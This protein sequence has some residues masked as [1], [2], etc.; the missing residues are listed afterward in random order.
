[1]RRE[2]ENRVTDALEN[3]FGELD[4]RLSIAP[5]LL[6][7]AKN[8]VED[9]MADYLQELFR[10]KDGS[11]LE[12]LDDQ[13]LEVRYRTL[14]TNSVGYMLLT[15][16]GV[17]PTIYFSDEDF[18]GIVDFNTRDTLNTLGVATGD[19]GQMCL[20]EIARTVRAMERQ[21]Q[22][23]KSHICRDPEDEYPVIEEI[24]K[25]ERSKDHDRTELQNGER[26]PSAQST[27]S[28]RA[29]GDPWE[30][31]IDETPVSAT[32][33]QSDL[34]EP[35]DQREADGAS[36]GDREGSAEPAGSDHSADGESRRRDGGAESEGSDD[37]GAADE[38]HPAESRGDDPGGVDL[39]LSGHDFD[40]R[41]DIPFYHHHEEKQEIIRSGKAL[42]DH[43]VT[44][45][46][47]LADHEDRKERGIFVKS[48]FDPDPVEMT[49]ANGQAAGYQAFDDLLHVWRGN[50]EKP[51]A[52]EFLRWSYVADTIEGMI[53]MEQWFAPE[54]QPLP[55]EGEQITLLAES[56]A[57]KANTFVFPQAAIDYIL[58]SGSGI[59]R[60]KFRI[61]E[62]FQLGETSEE[63]VRFLK[64]EYGTGGRTSA[65]PG[66]GLW[67]DHDSKGITIKNGP[68]GAS[69]TLRWP[70]VEKRIREL[71]AAN[72]YLSESEKAA[73]PS[74][75][76]ARGDRAERSRMASEFKEIVAE[77]ENDLYELGEKSQLPSRFYLISS[78]DALTDGRKKVYARTSEGDFVLP[79][80][81]SPLETIIANS[82][83][84]AGRCNTLLADLNGELTKPLEPT[85][86]E[87]NPP[88][89][90][91]REYLIEAGAIVHVGAQE[92]EVVFA[93]ADSFVIQ[94]VRFPLMQ[95]EYS[96][97]EFLRMVAENPLNDGICKS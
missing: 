50:L 34:H 39:Q 67:E 14:L 63:N 71:I 28:G 59:E 24:P 61:F 37:L 76:Q 47:Y 77:Y 13:N 41:S 90:P 11:F 38:Q 62:H 74:Y 94:D 7:A 89:P 75:L 80:M 87:L 32:A 45:A 20:S 92:Y 68:G 22:E 9:N 54:E 2:Y 69:V 97:D 70:K 21:P 4:N 79:V 15:R 82:P 66:T 6:S 25:T 86:E 33:P 3:S 65:I 12:E 88:A 64:N 49:L 19:I 27:A 48:F 18:R 51:E 31:R 42:K 78:A 85:E 53:V 95:T 96:R 35:A 58:A 16:C 93:G 44:I 10:Y 91:K 60:G 73:Y 29:G 30:I 36:D 40:A 55:T 43:R 46:A 83:G 72:R 5:A 8:A 57:E 26:I 84:P 1:M 56:Q 23:Q 52:E 81:R 17:D